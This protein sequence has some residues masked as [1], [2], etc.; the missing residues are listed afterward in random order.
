MDKNRIEDAAEQG[1]SR[2]AQNARCGGRNGAGKSNRVLA[3]AYFDKLD[4]PDSHDL[5]FSNCPV[6]IRMPGGV[7]GDWSVNLT[8]PMPIAH[9]ARGFP[10]RDA[11][12]GGLFRFCFA[13]CLCALRR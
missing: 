3:F 10:S 8:A 6:R 9:Q 1:A 4:L 11:R 7:A 5:N 12:I 13:P 2:V